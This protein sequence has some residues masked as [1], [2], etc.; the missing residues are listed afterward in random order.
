MG[1]SPTANIP[2]QFSAKSTTMDIEKCRYTIEVNP[3]PEEFI[4]VQ[5]SDD[6]QQEICYIS[7]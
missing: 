2:L 6:E 5:E 1:A 7:L 3:P 4:K